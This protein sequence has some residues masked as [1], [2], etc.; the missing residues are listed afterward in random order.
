[1]KETTQ[2]VIDQTAPKHLVNHT[3]WC[4]RPWCRA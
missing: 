2:R 1:M 4:P 3:T